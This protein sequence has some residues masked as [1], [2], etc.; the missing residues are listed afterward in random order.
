MSSKTALDGSEMRQTFHR[1]KACKDIHEALCPEDEWGTL[2]S[3]WSSSL[4]KVQR[5][6]WKILLASS[7]CPA[8]KKNGRPPLS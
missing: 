5:I 6:Q 1:V 7:W 3:S 8:F 4:F 2:G